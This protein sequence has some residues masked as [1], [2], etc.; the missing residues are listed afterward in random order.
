MRTLA[1][2]AV[3]VV[4]VLNGC[5]TA[6]KNVPVRYVPPAQYQSYNCYQLQLEFR[7]NQERVAELAGKLDDKANKDGL[8]GV[9]GAVIF[10]PMLFALGGSDQQEADYATLKGEGEAM[11]QAAFTKKCG[12]LT[13]K[14][15]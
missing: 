2:T 1:L 9:V 15:P 11:Q 5:A 8:T 13:P 10:L 7:R 4:L 3:A 12:V 6:S 14:P